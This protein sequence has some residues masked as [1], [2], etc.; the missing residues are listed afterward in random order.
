[1]VN[2]DHNLI[3]YVA[4]RLILRGLKY[5]DIIYFAAASI[6]NDTAGIYVLNTCSN[7]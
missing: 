7:L 6:V 1:M 4:L 5:Y 3:R 2:A